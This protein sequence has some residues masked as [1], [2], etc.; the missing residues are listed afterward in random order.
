MVNQ[1][2][3]ERSQRIYMLIDQGR[4]MKMPFDG[5]SLLDYS[6]NAS[7][8]LSHIVLKK[9]DHAGIAVFSR[10]IEQIVKADHKS[11]QLKRIANALYNVSTDFAESDFNRLYTDLRY[12]ITRRSLFFLFSNFE[13]LDAL[14]RQLPYLRAISKNHILVVIFFKNKLLKEMVEKTDHENMQQVYDEIIAEKFEY[15][16]KL[17]RQELSK[18][19]I[20]SIYTLPENLSVGVINKYLEIKARGIL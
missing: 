6:I 3:E 11:F 18:Y 7:M 19:G 4:T 9:K 15:E 14:Y 8:A 13:T 2:Q 12:K 5:L 20:H 16:K 1:Y 10:K 17:I